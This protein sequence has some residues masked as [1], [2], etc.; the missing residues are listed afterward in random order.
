MGGISMAAGDI[1]LSNSK[2]NT[3]RR[4]PKRYEYKYVQRLEKRKRGL[5]LYRG[6]WLHDMLMEYYDG[7]GWEA[8]HAKYTDEFMSMFE[9]EREEY[10]DLPGETER[11]MRSYIRHYEKRDKK[12][13][14]VD[15]ELDEILTLPSG[16]RF[17]FIIDLVVEEPDGG[18]WL[19]DHKTVKSFMDPDFMLLDTQLTRYFWCAEYMGYKPLR[20]VMFNEIRTKAPTVPRVLKSGQLSQA[21]N[22]DTDFYTY[23][24]EIV[25]HG[26][27]PTPYAATLRRLKRNT[28]SFFRRTHLP[29][30]KPLTRRMMREL[31]MTRAEMDFAHE[32]N[33]FPR[34]TSKNCVWDCDFKD[35]CIAELMGAN[36]DPMIEM[37]YNVR[38]ERKEVETNE[39]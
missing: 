1:R 27:D 4:C 25:R 37:N 6:S 15:S 10:G 2:I 13:R 36:V 18:L 17:N 8:A 14:I 5:P 28:G 20:G 21:K 16:D 9:E 11:I 23:A 12:L 19:W 30:D 7:E 24:R 38:P 35:L 33:Q 32:H 29:K 31:E 22:I 3:F 26:L 39:Y 34:S